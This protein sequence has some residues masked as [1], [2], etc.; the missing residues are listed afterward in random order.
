MT[1]LF[2]L[3][4][5]PMVYP[6]INGLLTGIKGSHLKMETLWSY[7]LADLITVCLLLVVLGF[8]DN[9]ASKLVIGP[10]RNIVTQ[11]KTMPSANSLA[12]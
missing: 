2:T 6:R 9:Q 10:K 5:R 11:I 7:P 12:E 1:I 4:E 3:S 8:T